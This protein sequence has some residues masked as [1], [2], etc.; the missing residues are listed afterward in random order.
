MKMDVAI[1]GGG[2]AGMSAGIFAGRAGLDVVCF[3]AVAVGGQAGLS[4]EIA[5]YP[6]FEKISGY[7]LVLKMEQHA[8]SCGVK[9]AFETV[10]KIEKQANGFK[11]ICSK[12]EHFAKKVVLACGGKVKHLGIVG[13]EK[14]FGKGVSYCA[15]C[16]GNFFKNK[17]VA[18]VGGGDS[19]V[20]NVEY[21]SRLAESV[22][23][24]CRSD[25]LKVA[26]YKVKEIQKL[27]NVSVLKNA[28][29]IEF[30]GS[31]HLEKIII[32]HSGEKKEIFV[33]GV[34]VSIGQMPCL[35]E[36]NFDLA[37]DEKGYVV[38]DSCQQTN[39]K[40]LF[41]CGDIVSKEFKQV[42]SACADGARAGNSCVRGC[43]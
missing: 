13:E 17:K 19:A 27:A 18:V 21:L 2:P 40:N 8:K 28:K 5:N 32:E 12:S 9:F 30:L 34:F 20:E 41:A 15:S 29:P 42:V 6:G 24:L 43:K 39:V 1:I 4:Y 26:D 11:L 33:E 23:L 7:D 16:D 35:P 37:L 22:V 38:V 10:E 14:F 25:K 36:M 31:D 3:E